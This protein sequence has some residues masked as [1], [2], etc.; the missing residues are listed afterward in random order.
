MGLVSLKGGGYP[1][2]DSS[3]TD[4]AQNHPLGTL[5]VDSSG[6]E[7][8]YA[9]GCSTIP[10]MGSLMVMIPN[11]TLSSAGAPQAIVATQ[12]STAATQG[13][14]IGIVVS[15][16]QSTSVFGWFQIY[17]PCTIAADSTQAANTQMF[18]SSLNT[19]QVA[20][21]TTGVRIYGLS[22]TSSGGTAS[23]QAAFAQ[24]PH[25]QTA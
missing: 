21:T 18:A 24:Y 1:G 14:P 12:L 13:G 20:A 22:I 17:G 25:I 9:R 23:A 10:V 2:Q 16:A 3:A 7:Y 6:G 8:I 15:T 19:G 11:S 5:A 4:T